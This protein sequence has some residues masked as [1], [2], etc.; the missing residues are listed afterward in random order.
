MHSHYLNYCYD[1][2]WLQKRLS[3][4]TKTS[5]A[6]IRTTLQQSLS[7]ADSAIAAAVAAVGLP[8]AIVRRLGVPLDRSSRAW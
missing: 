3:I 1:L 7:G 5:A 6:A 2:D 4:K 8:F